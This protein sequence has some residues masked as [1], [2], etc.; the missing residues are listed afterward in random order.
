M[1]T[2]AQGFIPVEQKFM[3]SPAFSFSGDVTLS[4]RQN[5]LTFTGSA[6]IVHNCSEIKSY[7]IKFKG[8]VDPKNVM[9]PVGEKPRDRNDNLVFSGSF[10]NIDSVHIYPAFLSQQ[11]SYTDVG[12]VNATGYLWFDKAKGRYLITSAEKIADPA[13]NGNLIAFDKNFCTIAGEGKLNFGA[14]FNLFKMSTAGKFNHNLDSGKVTIQALIGLDFY[15]SASALKIM[16]DE[17]KMLPTLKA[18]NLNSELNTKGMK[19]LMGVQ[20]ASQIRDEM[21]LFGSSK[22]LPKEFVYKILL[23]DVTL[24]WNESTSSFRSVGKI[25]IGFIAQQPIN[26]YVDGYIEIQRRRSGDMIDVYLK[27]N[28]STWYYFSYFSGVLMAQSANSSFNSALSDTKVKDRKDPNS[29][30]RMPYTY[31]IAVETQLPR[32]LRR[33]A[34][35]S[36]DN[37]G[38]R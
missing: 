36:P 25:G 26:V 23:N 29:T 10:I 9:I 5:F 11:K 33:M 37:T 38:T 18:V 24:K 7:S 1:T 17:L 8:P 15:F 2:T 3:L 32:F 30:V 31:M 28:Q 22:T 16:I 14:N 21:S 13:R 4:A 34:S 20:A 6:G 27:A 12:L 35:D 19:D